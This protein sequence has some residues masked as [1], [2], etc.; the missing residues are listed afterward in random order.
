MGVVDDVL[1]FLAFLFLLGIC[2]AVAFGVVLP[3]FYEQDDITSNVLE[4]KS[5][6]TSEGIVSS[7]SYDGTMTK[8][9]AVLV[10]QVQDTGLPYP[11]RYVIEPD[12]N[13]STIDGLDASVDSSY[14]GDIKSYG[15][16]AYN[17]MHGLDSTNTGK[18]KVK[19]NYGVTDDPSDDFYYIEKQ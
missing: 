4:D 8:L 12:K 5:S 18:Y 1:D 10:T 14:G 17:K 6:P 3:T 13:F 9:E 19:Y 16:D 7:T 15:V 2:I 11:K